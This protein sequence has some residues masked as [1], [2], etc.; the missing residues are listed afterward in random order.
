[1]DHFLKIISCMMLMVLM[2]SQFLLNSSYR[3]RMIDDTLNGR[4]L[5]TYETLIYTGSVTLNAF[6]RYT[7]NSATILLN[8]EPQK[9]VDLFPV[10]LNVC[11]GDVVEIQLKPSSP[12]FYVYLSDMK[13]QIKIDNQQSAY[14]IKSGINRIVKVLLPE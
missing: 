13:G 5:K 14:L 7:P 1:M 11:D 12:S 4:S 3:E 2:I 6:G 8:G 10:E 9:T